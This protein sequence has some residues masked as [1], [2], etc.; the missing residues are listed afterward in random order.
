[1][2]HS[3]ML[4][5]L[6][7]VARAGSIRTAASRMNVAASAVNRQILALE[8]ELGMPIFERLS[9]RLRLTAPGEILIGHV[10]QTLK[11]HSRIQTLMQDLKGFRRGEIKIAAMGGIGPAA[12][13]PIIAAFRRH[14]PGVSVVVRVLPVGDLIAAV[15]AEDVDFGFALDLPAHSG[16]QTFAT[17]DCP[18]GAVVARN[19]DLASHTSV[20]L[21]D[22][23]AHPLILPD[24]GLT[25][26]R[27]LD[28]AFKRSTVTA[29]PAFE[30]NSIELMLG[31]VQQ[32]LGVTFLNRLNI[33]AARQR[34]EVVLVPLRNRF[35]KPQ[36]LS[37][38]GPAK[39]G[40]ESLA[41]LM[42]EDFRAAFHEFKGAD[43]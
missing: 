16:L 9:R 22:C 24:Q 41:N 7:E 15:N 40:L 28:D 35:L 32:G 23:I 4:R 10:R 36:R 2:L 11:E 38:V 13:P 1:M 30:S 17:I 6:D 42:V 37:V 39:H 5:Y 3:R 29:R 34:G 18:I 8:E 19:H 20:T 26:R 33:E 12:L 43:D 25:L 14:R 31:L 21:S 27:L